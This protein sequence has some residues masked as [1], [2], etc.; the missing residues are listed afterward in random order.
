MPVGNL[1]PCGHEDGVAAGAYAVQN[2]HYLFREPRN[3]RDR[4]GELQSA[5]YHMAFVEF[6]D[7]G[8]F[9]DRKQMEALF[10]LFDRLERDEKRRGNSGHLLLLLYAHGW[11]HNA[12]QCD[13]NVICF[14]RL[15]ERMDILEQK[16]QLPQ[17]RRRVVGIYVGWRGLSLNAEVLSNITFWTRKNTA[18][19]VGQGGVTEL[20]T[21]LNDY[22]ASRNRERDGDK[23]QLVIAGHS[24]G[25]QVIYAALS[26]SIMERA[27]RAVRLSNV[28]NCDDIGP[29]KANPEGLT[30]YDTATSFGDL[31]VLVNPAFE[32]SQYE[33]LF[34]IA[35]N[36]CYRAD[37][38]PVMMT[39]TSS[40][41]WA[42]RIA[43][44]LGRKVS[45]FFER[46]R[47][48]GQE[49]SIIR[50]V[51]HAD[52]YQTHKLEWLGAPPDPDEPAF[53]KE[54]GACGCPYLE[55]TSEFNWRAFFSNRIA[56]SLLP[57]GAR[58]EQNPLP[59][60]W[61]KNERQY[62]NVY[63]PDVR[64]TGDGNYSA[65]YPYLV[66][67]ADEGII[68]DHNTIYSEP[69]VRFLHSFFLIHI[70]YGRPFEADGCVK[71]KDVEFCALDGLVPCEQSCRLPDG[72]SCSG[73]EAEDLRTAIK[74]PGS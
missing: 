15:L 45:T 24:F 32:G 69:F 23:T 4:S 64:L 8:W 20:L 52:R 19:R 44:P 74:P 36:R 56:N 51:G 1:P 9:A 66:I 63:G 67:K 13:D 40:A 54:E 39:V 71:G 31:V 16:L 43:F 38:R 25:G 10:A 18:A 11:K 48:D 58:P 70:A 21:R 6:D 50:T 57:S 29:G 60:R 14:S 5:D 53:V 34:H 73:R 55:P 49:D 42:T 12:S 47:S 68:K 2:R 72:K 61:F 7:Q 62:E 17:M 41:D 27:G 33:P 65:N 3:E 59:A 30:C 37:Q 46:A 22:R 35:T 26:H 28:K